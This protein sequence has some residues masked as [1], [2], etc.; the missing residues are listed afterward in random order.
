MNSH[1]KTVEE[2]QGFYGQVNSFIVDNFIMVLSVCTLMQLFI[3]NDQVR[4]FRCDSDIVSTLVA[5]ETTAALIGGLWC[6]FMKDRIPLIVIS[7]FNYFLYTKRTLSSFA[8]TLSNAKQKW[9]WVCLVFQPVGGTCTLVIC[10]P[11]NY[12]QDIVQW[13]YFYMLPHSIFKYI[14]Y[15]DWTIHIH[16]W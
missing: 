3:I 16:N 8:K 6:Q 5:P 12:I 15:A 13:S 9:L 2:S 10:I 14:T 11:E 4:C 7:I 1:C